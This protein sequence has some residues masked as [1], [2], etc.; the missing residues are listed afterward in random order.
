MANLSFVLFYG[1]KFE[2]NKKWL[3]MLKKGS[4]FDENQK[5]TSP[6]Q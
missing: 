5:K 6:G 2:K 3:L 4:D 1:K